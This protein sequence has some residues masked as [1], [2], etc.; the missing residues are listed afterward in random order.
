M[1]V[2]QSI[3]DD[4]RALEAEAAVKIRKI[5]VDFEH[6]EVR[7]RTRSLCLSNCFVLYAVFFGCRHRAYRLTIRILCYRID[8]TNRALRTV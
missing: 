7:E 8:Q 4:R 3:E 5:E 1:E 6:F 2:G